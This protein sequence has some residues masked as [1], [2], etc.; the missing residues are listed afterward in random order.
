MGANVPGRAKAEKAYPKKDQ[1]VPG[2]YGSTIGLISL[3]MIGKL[4]ANLL[5]QFNKL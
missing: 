2:C 4:V 5:K 3:G 1:T